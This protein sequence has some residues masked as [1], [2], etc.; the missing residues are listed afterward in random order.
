MFFPM[1]SASP[2]LRRRVS[3][4]YGPGYGLLDAL[5]QPKLVPI[6]EASQAST[7]S[8]VPQDTSISPLRWLTRQVGLLDA[9][10]DTET[11]PAAASGRPMAERGPIGRVPFRPARYQISSSADGSG[12]SIARQLLVDPIVADAKDIWRGVRLGNAGIYKT[13]ANTVG[14]A[15][16]ANDFLTRTT[17]YGTL[18]KDTFAQDLKDWLDS[19]AVYVA[20]PPEDVPTNFADEFFT[21]LGQAPA[22]VAQMLV[23]ARLLGPVAGMASVN[24][25]RESDQGLDAAEKAAAEGVLF[26]LGAKALEPLNSIARAAGFG[27]LSAAIGL[28]N[29]GDLGDAV[30]SAAPMS[31]LGAAGIPRPKE[32]NLLPLQLAYSDFAD[33]AKHAQNRLDVVRGLSP[34][35]RKQEI[36][37]INQRPGLLLQEVARLSDALRGYKTTRGRTFYLPS[38]PWM[39]GSRILDYGRKKWWKRFDDVEVK[40][41]KARDPRAQRNADFYLESE[42][43]RIPRRR[44]NEI[45]RRARIQLDKE[46]RFDRGAE[47]LGKT[48]RRRIRD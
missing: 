27:S 46:G 26:G 10:N 1:T 16:D 20:P 43:V 6:A 40:R 30:A 17:G 11:A 44:E 37:Q 15:N 22:D 48:I 14:L 28:A 38:S 25:V 29:G 47:D 33:A 19:A 21:A 32:P 4:A 41:E 42:G 3:P 34:W 35:R 36:V 23:G 7:S 9:L 31:L 2:R 24:A 18:S 13:L 12:H 8:S 5:D 39:L 45:L